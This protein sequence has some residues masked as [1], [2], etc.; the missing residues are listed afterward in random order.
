MC[1]ALLQTLLKQ[2]GTIRI[3]LIGRVSSPLPDEESCTQ[4]S[5]AT[6]P[7]ITQPEGGKAGI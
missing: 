4:R 1:Q 7:K 2:Y 3:T 5:D 6:F